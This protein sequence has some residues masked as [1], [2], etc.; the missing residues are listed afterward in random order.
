MFPMVVQPLFAEASPPRLLLNGYGRE[1]PLQISEKIMRSSQ[2]NLMRR[3]GASFDQKQPDPLTFFLDRN[4]G[5]HII[6]DILR[7]AGARVAVHDDHFPTDAKDN[8]WLPAV[9]KNGWVVL[10]KDKRIKDRG[11]ELRALRNARVKA[12][13]LTSGN[14]QGHDMAAIFVKAL[15][16]IQKYV[17]NNDPPFIARLTSQGKI[18]PIK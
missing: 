17:N 13:V 3:S 7:E 15:P 1:N 10:T 6:A 9:G 18:S 2:K 14:L 4:L 12:F 11:L 5:K 16:A 8:E